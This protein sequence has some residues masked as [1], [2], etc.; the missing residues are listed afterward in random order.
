MIPNGMPPVTRFAPSPT[1]QLHVGNIRTALQN[2]LF[3]RR[4][5]GKF[6]LRLDDTDTERS[7]AAFA[8]G[9]REDLDW[10]GLRPDAEYRQSDRFSA[11]EA[12][13][14]R[15]RANG[16]VYPAFE[17][18]EELDLKRK[19]LLGRHLPPVYDRAALALTD[20]DRARLE[21]DGIRPHW[22]F[23]LDHDRAIDWDDLVRGPQHLDPRTMSDPVVRRADGSWLYM[24]P[25]AIDDI[26]LGI[27]H[28]VR[29]E[30]HVT[31][32]GFQVQMFEALG[33]TPPAFAHAA[34][35]VGTDG[36][37][38]KRE[39]SL[40]VAEL[41][42]DGIEPLA[43]LALLA[44]LGTSR[45]VEPI[46]DIAPLVETFDFSGFG[47]APAHF[48]GA[49]LH[50]LN[51]KMLHVMPF[52]RVADRLPAGMP[53]AGWHAIR[54]NVVRVEDAA[55]G[56]S[57]VTGPIAAPAFDQAD[58]AYLAAAADEAAR[59]DWTSA[60]WEQLTTA[61]KTATGR[62]GKPLF[63]P[64]RRALT[65]RDDGPGMA[66]ILPLIGRDEAVR[67]LHA[68]VSA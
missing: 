15:L 55:D 3:A 65:G 57:V 27:T 23:R 5:G 59:I 14:D 32:S 62:K 50:A 2:F 48:D 31:N 4:H 8:D 6:L 30:D 49:E 17:T 51:T 1:G 13:F 36:K 61:L 45:P 68:A 43:V 46:A 44:R 54:G 64:L 56:W 40:G 26:D 29:G 18:S 21:A 66:D 42:D 58:R 28:V 19:I 7:T 52:E 38:S 63:L 60:P 25:S 33:A 12:A 34:L 10:L 67:R 24:L 9:I 35:L 41:R 39:G 22:R 11:Y 20:A 37:L 47:R 53:E 16:R